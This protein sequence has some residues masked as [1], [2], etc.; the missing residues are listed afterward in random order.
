MNKRVLIGSTLKVVKTC[1][2]CPYFN[3]QDYC[4]HEKSNHQQILYGDSGMPS[5]CPLDDMPNNIFDPR[6]AKKNVHKINIQVDV[7][8][9][10]SNATIPVHATKQSSGYDVIT[11][12]NITILAKSSVKIKTGLA[13]SI[14]DGYELQVRPRSSTLHKKG[15]IVIMGTIDAD[16]RGEVSISVFN[17]NDFDVE[18]KVTPEMPEIAIAQL[19]VR[20]VYYIDFNEVNELDSTERGEGGFGSTSR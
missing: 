18:L 9:L 19:V 14:P 1:C 16:Y 8:R 17:P 13:F 20:K 3:E 6:E 2:E 4:T 5:D 10:N 7:K 15:L 12:D 11:K